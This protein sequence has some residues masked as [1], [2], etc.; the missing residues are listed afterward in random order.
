MQFNK[1]YLYYKDLQAVEIL[2]MGE[3]Y[4][5]EFLENWDISGWGE[6]EVVCLPL[7]IQA[8][9]WASICNSGKKQVKCKVFL[10]LY[11]WLLLYTDLR[12]LG[13]GKLLVC[14]SW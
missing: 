12:I 14:L 4:I 1:S 3:M 5:F 7:Q 11:N 2:F 10:L 8:V 13:V 6:T 9:L